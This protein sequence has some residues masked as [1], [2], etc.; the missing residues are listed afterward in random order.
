MD[1]FIAP[2][3]RVPFVFRLALWIVRRRTG[4]DLLPPRLLTWYPQAAVSSAAI[5]A[6]IAHSDGRCT[7]RMLKMVRMTVSFTASCP[8]CV[9]LN[10]E[11]WDELMTDEELR[12]LQGHVELG[13]VVS[14]TAHERLAIEFARL[15]SQ[16]PLAVPPEFGERLAA[17][18]T[19]REVVVLASTAAQVNYWA[20]LIQGLGCPPA[21]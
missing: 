1:A 17:A 11:G 3:A 13:A 5:E 2:P 18:F 10:S 19:E 21:G 12:A 20:R 6:L 4:A 8:F 14:F 9:G 16:T 7:E 15:V